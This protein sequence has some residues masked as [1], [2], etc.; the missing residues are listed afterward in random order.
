MLEVR[1]NENFYEKLTR[2]RVPQ[3]DSEVAV[4]KPSILN[5]KTL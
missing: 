3:Q 5:M 2:F 4:L 1:P